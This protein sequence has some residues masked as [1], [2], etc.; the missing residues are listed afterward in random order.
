MPE[1]NITPALSPAEWRLVETI[2]GLPESRLSSRIFEVLDS[3][4]FY[5]RNP[6]CGGM[7]VEGFP[8]GEPAST[9]EECHQV[10]DLLETINTRI[11][12][13]PQH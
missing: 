5:V 1:P 10:W 12:E 6:R 2:R 13:T 8:C 11:S 4:L 3:L 9:C 7:G